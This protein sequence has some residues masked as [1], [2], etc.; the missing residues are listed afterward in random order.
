MIDH[1]PT[2]WVTLTDTTPGI[3]SAL[4]TSPRT[5]HDTATRLQT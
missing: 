1:A 3:I 2:V 4:I 5:D